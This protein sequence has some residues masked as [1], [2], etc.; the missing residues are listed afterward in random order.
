MINP[1][2][3]NFRLAAAQPDAPSTG[4]VAPESNHARSLETPSH[5]SIMKYESED[6][7]IDND[8]HHN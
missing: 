7:K 4:F 1:S 8:G 2:D 5:A 3:N 6:E